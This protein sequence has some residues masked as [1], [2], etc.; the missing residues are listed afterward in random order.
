[1]HVVGL[2][3]FNVFGPREDYKG[4]ATSMVTKL[5]NQIRSGRRP[6]IFRDG[7]QRRDFVYV[8]DAVRANLLALEG[9]ESGIVNVGTGKATTFNAVIRILNQALGASSEPDYFD[10]PYPFYQNETEADL[11]LARTL[12]G[13]QPGFDTEKG[14]QDY[15]GKR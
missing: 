2:R 6:R 13:Y 7:E 11:T 5:A 3:Y 10:N 9:K 8:K 4:S 12:I 1:V 15:L 14:I